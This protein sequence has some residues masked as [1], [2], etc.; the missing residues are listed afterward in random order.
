MKRERSGGAAAKF[1][2][3]VSFPGQENLGKNFQILREVSV[4][5]CLL[6]PNSLQG[7]A[8]QDKQQRMQ[9]T[10]SYPEVRFRL[11]H[12]MVF[13]VVGHR[14]LRFKHVDL[15]NHALCRPNNDR[16]FQAKH[17]QG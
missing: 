16:S 17:L 1:G 6:V 3:A 15:S 7:H 10:A 2:P 12:S 13:D 5:N 4:N 8:G 14:R 11:T 9:A